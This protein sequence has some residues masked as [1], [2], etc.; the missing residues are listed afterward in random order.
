MEMHIQGLNDLKFDLD[1]ELMPGDVFG[2]YKFSLSI[3]KGH[4]R[5]TMNV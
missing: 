5:P 1:I 4:T 3:Y 2:I